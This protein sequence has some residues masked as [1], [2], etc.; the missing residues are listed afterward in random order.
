MFRFTCCFAV[1]I[2]LAGVSSAKAAPYTLTH[3]FDD[4]TPTFAD[5][6]GVSVAMDANNVLIG[7]QDDNT[8]GQDIGQAHLFDVTT[9]NLLH[10]FD[11]PTATDSDRFGHSVAIDGNHV[12]IGAHDDDTNGRGVGQAHL[13]DA[14]TGNLLRTFNDPTVTSQDQFGISVAIDGN[15]V[16]IGAYEDDTNGIDVGQ[17]YLL[18]VTTGNLL[19]TF[20]DP[21]VTDRDQFGRSVAISGNNVLIGAPR[22]E[23]NGDGGQ[24]H[25]FD[26]VT[27]NLL[28]TLDD[29]TVTNSDNFGRS[30]AIDG[31]NVLV[32]APYDN[33]HGPNVGQVHLFDAT[34]GILLHTFDD[35]TVTSDDGFGYSVAIDGDN[36]LIG[37]WKDETNGRFVGQAYLFDA[38]SGGLVQTFDDPTVTSEDYF[39][40]AV[41]IDGNNV[42]IGAHRDNTYGPSVGQAHLYVVPEP[43]TFILSAIGLV[44]L[45]LFVWRR[46]FSCRFTALLP[47]LIVLVGVSSAQAAPYS[48]THTFNDPTVT[49]QDWFGYSVAIDGSHILIGAVT[50]DTNGENVGQVHLY[51][52]STGNL[53]QTFDDPTVTS[54]DAF[55]NSIAIDTAL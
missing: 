7:A 35:P 3:T 20:I 27:G 40:S 8:N 5:Y 36:V 28:H 30:A 13:F 49:T 38:V 16:L 34:T 23:T 9:G 21:T 1:L 48:L 4:P 37:A 19:H 2:V 26:A 52:A 15:N 47:L 46:R 51:D 14:V 17:A 53:L 42:L 22:D 43:S 41:A 50:D 39:G 29:P 31:N 24:A 10:T 54:A 33:T 32:G 45:L 11:D 44:G 6:F 18:D 12:L 55:G 25:L